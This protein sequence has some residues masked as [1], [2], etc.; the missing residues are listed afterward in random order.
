MG[1]GISQCLWSLGKFLRQEA[2]L[3]SGVAE[4]QALIRWAS[5][6]T[7]GG[8]QLH[9]PA[10]EIRYSKSVLLF[11]ALF[12]I[13][14]FLNFPLKRSFPAD[15]LLQTYPLHVS[16]ASHVLLQLISKLITD[17]AGICHLMRVDAQVG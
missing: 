15:R 9:C 14:R 10:W 6:F 4:M 5:G 13:L 16:Y 17:N 2:S 7:D 3:T 11:L 1:E 12:G 8:L